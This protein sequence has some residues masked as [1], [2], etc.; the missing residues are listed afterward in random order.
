MAEKRKQG[1]PSKGSAALSVPVTFRL[2]VADRALLEQ[3]A[4][5]R[6]S[7]PSRVAREIVERSLRGRESD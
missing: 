3:L 1:R 5:E 2:T 6:E 7:S 4:S